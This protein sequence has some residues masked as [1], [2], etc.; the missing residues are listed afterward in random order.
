MAGTPPW[1]DTHPWLGGTPPCTGTPPWAD[2]PLGQV[3]PM[4][5]ERAVH[6][7]LE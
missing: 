1:A 7:L 4:V 2:T 6:I 5:N 3:H